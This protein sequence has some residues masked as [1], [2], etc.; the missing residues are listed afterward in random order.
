M[1]MQYIECMRAKQRRYDCLVP[2]MYRLR[3]LWV[4][5]RLLS[6]AH[7]AIMPPYHIFAFQLVPEHQPQLRCAGPTAESYSRECDGRDTRYIKTEL[8][9]STTARKMLR[10]GSGHSAHALSSHPL[11]PALDS[12][13]SGAAHPA[14]CAVAVVPPP[15]SLFSPQVRLTSRL[16]P[17]LPY[18]A[19]APNTRAHRGWWMQ[20]NARCIQAEETSSDAPIGTCGV[21]WCVKAALAT[22]LPEALKVRKAPGKGKGA[23]GSATRSSAREI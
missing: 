22:C 1:T 15:L 5:T 16:Q 23:Q 2:A 10:S 18:D 8:S 11:L 13:S 19:S 14:K 3:I 21:A 4:Y 20:E 9:A 6:S 12:S 17:V 7:E